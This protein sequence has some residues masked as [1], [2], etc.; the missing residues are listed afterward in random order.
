MTRRHALKL[1]TLALFA[2]KLPA[3]LDAAGI[4]TVD[5]GQWGN[6]TFKCDGRTVTFTGRELFAALEEGRRNT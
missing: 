6:V 4:L 1:A 5:L 2:G 3:K